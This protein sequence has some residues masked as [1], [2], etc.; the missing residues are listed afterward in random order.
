GMRMLDCGCGPGTLTLGFA[1]RVA[2][3]ET[4]GIDREASQFA[5]T[6]ETAQHEGIDNLRFE[7]GDIYELPFAD[8]N[9]DVVFTSAVLGSVATPEKVVAEMARVLKPGGVLALKEFDHDGDIIWP[10]SPVIAHSI[11]LYHRL[12]AH[13][14]HAA[15]AG[16]RL[17]EF[18]HSAGCRTDY[19]HAFYEEHTDAASLRRQVERNNYLVAEILGQQYEALGWSTREALNEE[20]Q[21]WL[22]FAAN[23]AAIYC[24]SWCEAVGI[25]T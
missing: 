5:A 24:S 21:A 14:G 17:R 11:A 16:R 13:N 25:K 8:A 2:P 19:F 3:G 1:Q 23:P 9:F 6:I 18:I 22:E 15:L 4:I 7:T 20:A 12:R 10:Q